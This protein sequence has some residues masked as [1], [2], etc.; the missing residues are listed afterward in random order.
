M[1]KIIE[2]ALTAYANV[3]IEST[4][5]SKDGGVVLVIRSSDEDLT[6]DIIEREVEKEV[7]EEYG[8]V[9]V[10]VTQ[11]DDND[12]EKNANNALS[13]ALIMIVSVILICCIL[14]G[15]FLV[16]RFRK[17]N[18]IKTE[19]LRI[20]SVS[21]ATEMNIISNEECSP[22]PPGLLNEEVRDGKLSNESMYNNKVEITKGSNTSLIQLNEN[23]E[24]VDRRDSL[25]SM[26]SKQ[27]D[28]EPNNVTKGTT[29]QPNIGDSKRKDSNE[30]MYNHVQNTKTT[31]G[32]ITIDQ[33]TK[34]EVLLKE[35][36]EISEGKGSVANEN[37]QQIDD[38]GKK[39]TTKDTT[40]D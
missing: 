16:L 5:I 13:F 37:N 2:K 23:E 29:I 10:T 22:S 28:D 35:N 1:G 25:E 17:N 30:S 20:N 7:K 40:V 14:V 38:E 33:N 31:K 6:S 36:D 34:D 8:D 27:I 3:E 21:Q 9:D 24:M 12:D 39:T 32:T 18:K 4:T 26:Y 15:V 11:N 19:D